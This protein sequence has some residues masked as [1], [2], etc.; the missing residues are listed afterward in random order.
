VLTR[1]LDGVDPRITAEIQHA[2]EHVTGVTAITDVQ[3]RWLGHQLHADVAISVD[4]AIS[5]VQAKEIVAAVRAELVSH[6][7]ALRSVNVTFEP[8]SV[9]GTRATATH[10]GHGAHHAPKPFRFDSKLGAGTLEIVDTPAGERMRL[11]LQ[12]NIPGLKASVSISRPAGAVELL[13]LE[14]KPGVADVMESA[15]AP[16]EPHD[17]RAVLRL[18]VED[19]H[20]QLPFDMVEPEAHA[21]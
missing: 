11:V 6:L 2:A 9:A 4:S 10:E 13:S 7:A 20:E 12:Q 8:S 17:F 21:H 14:P 5:L 1:A 18:A 3:A 16:A 19:K 15:N